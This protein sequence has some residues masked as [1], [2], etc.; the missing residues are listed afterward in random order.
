[1]SSIVWLDIETTGLNPHAHQITEIGYILD[2]VET[3]I[4]PPHN[5]DNADPVALDIQHYYTRIEPLGRADEEELARLYQT[6]AGRT[7]AGAN[8]RFDAAFLANLFEDE[9]WNY[10]LL[11]VEAYAAGRFGW[12]APIGLAKTV[13]RL[14][15]MGYRVPTPTHGAL[16]DARAAKAVYEACRNMQVGV[17]GV[18]L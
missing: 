18:Y 5:L 14:R 9:P 15:E 10:R 4:I 16:D 12:E 1:V 8:P 7:L 17:V 6:L 13:E 11:D 2:N 3:R